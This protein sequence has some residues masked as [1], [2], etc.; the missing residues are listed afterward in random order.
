MI[1]MYTHTKYVSQLFLKLPH[2]DFAYN[3]LN[4][5]FTTTVTVELTDFIIDFKQ[6]SNVKNCSGPRIL[7][8]PQ[9]VV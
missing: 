1:W 3:K 5:Q 7:L 9:K 4:L 2:I 8:R 6:H